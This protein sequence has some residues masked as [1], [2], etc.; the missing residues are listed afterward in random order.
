MLAKGYKVYNNDALDW[1]L[2]IIGIRNKNPQPNQFDDTLVVFNQYIGAW[3]VSYYPITTDPSIHYLKNPILDKG[4]AVLKEGQYKGAY[5]I[6]KH[7]GNYFALCQRLGKVEVYREKDKDGILQMLNGSIESGFFGINIHKGPKKGRWGSDNHARYSAG[8]Q[9]FAST[10]HFQDF[11]LKCR[12]AEKSF[13]N[14]FT[15]TLLNEKD[16]E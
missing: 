10:Y 14:K 11:M 2:N 6:D 13:G 8:C 3:S 7:N 5:S 9:V 16:F 4:T 15:Y 1:N 12:Q